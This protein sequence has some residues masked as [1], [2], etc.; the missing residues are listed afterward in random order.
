MDKTKRKIKD[1]WDASK[2]EYLRKNYTNTT[3][4][5]LAQYLNLA[6]GSVIAKAKKLRLVKLCFLKTVLIRGI[7]ELNFSGVY[8][9][10]N[11]TTKKMYVGSSHNINKRLYTHLQQLRN[12]S[13]SN[14]DL[15]NDWINNEFYIGLLWKGDKIYEQWEQ[16]YLYG[17]P[18]H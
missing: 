7:D 1:F 16:R 15:Q 8:A 5:V 4:R 14:I 11:Q 18:A 13:H 3:N 12:L 6:I 9:I 17:F 2:I 10:V